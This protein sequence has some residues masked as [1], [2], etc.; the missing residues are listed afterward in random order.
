MPK[1]C[2]SFPIV[3]SMLLVLLQP[4]PFLLPV[5]VFLCP[6]YFLIVIFMLSVSCISLS[7]PHDGEACKAFPTN[8]R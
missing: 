5:R 6:I 8:K 1:P 2:L 4:F 3:L 7:I